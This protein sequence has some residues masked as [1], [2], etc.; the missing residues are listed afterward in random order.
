MI[1]YNNNMELKTAIANIEKKLPGYELPTAITT[2]EEFTQATDLGGK[3]KKATKE[4][5]KFR[6]FYAKPHYDTYKNIREQFEPFLSMLKEKEATLKPMMLAFHREEQK[7]KDAEQAKI[8][9]EALAN[10]KDGESIQVEVVN[11]IKTTE[12]AYGKSQVRT[13]KKW[14]VVDITKVPAEFLEV[15]SVAVNKAIKEGRV[16]A[17]I[18]EYEEQSMAISG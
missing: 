2:M 7:R 4:I 1:I 10:A 17:G 5:E 8:E 18:E 16:P 3:I 12:G 9:A 6:D 11:E 14:R 15:N 13:L